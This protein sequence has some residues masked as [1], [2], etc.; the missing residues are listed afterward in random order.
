MTIV[1]VHPT[2]TDRS[3]PV[4]DLAAEAEARG[5]G[6]IYLPEHTHVPVGSLEIAPGWT[7]A[8]RY[9]RTLDPLIA[10]SYIAATTSLEVGT[11]VALPAEHD[12][13]A[14]AKAIATLDHLSGGRVVV[15]VGFG[16]NRPEV[17]DHGYPARH[18][19][20]VVEE[21][22][23]LM[24]AI[25]TQDEASYE[26]RFRRM[27]P[28]WS[29][30]KPVRP[31]GPPVL[32]GCRVSDRNFTRIVDWADGWIPMTSGTALDDV[33]GDLARLRGRWTDAG[34][35]GEPMICF[36]FQPAETDHMARQIAQGIELGIDRMQV[37][38]EDRTRDDVMPI[39]DRLARA[40]TIAVG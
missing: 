25:W 6:S 3:M 21:T 28:S 10:A 9:Q 2:V 15:G 26:G 14:L 35:G 7:M 19:A 40:V 30:P 31:G 4:V 32:L 23:G 20:A 36:F 22:V 11:A 17:E 38:L 34:R 1:G 39:L 12:G 27:S 8:E 24:R 5:F 13:I 33:A 37:F 16:Y 18:R 29:W